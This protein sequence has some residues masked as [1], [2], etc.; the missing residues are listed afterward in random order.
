MRKGVPP[1]VVLLTV[2]ALVLA[3]CGGAATPT[4]GGA[5]ATQPPTP[6][7]PEAATVAKPQ[8][9]SEL[10]GGATAVLG[11]TVE[12]TPTPRPLPTKPP[13]PAPPWVAAFSDELRVFSD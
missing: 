8:P 3:G 10:I 6:K 1:L 7:L 9:T 4:P 13:T 11:A 12:P 2:L 5:A